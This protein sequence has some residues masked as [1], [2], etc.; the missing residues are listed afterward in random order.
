M[1]DPTEI[2]RVAAGLTKLQVA[3]LTTQAVVD[4][5]E[6]WVGGTNATLTNLRKKGLARSMGRFTEKGLAVRGQL[7]REA[8]HG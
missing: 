3:A 8:N 7:M 5:K 4:G 2:A 6:I 1:T